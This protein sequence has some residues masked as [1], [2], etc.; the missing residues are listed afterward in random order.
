[1]F[2]VINRKKDKRDRQKETYNSK[3][4]ECQYAATTHEVGSESNFV[5]SSFRSVKIYK[6]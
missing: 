6:T 1:M 5:R 3:L 2:N 4:G